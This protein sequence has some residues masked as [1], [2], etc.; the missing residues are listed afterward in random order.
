MKRVRLFRHGQSSANAGHASQDHKSIPLTSKGLEQ[1]ITVA[2]S[3][4]D[5]PHLIVTSPFERAQVTAQST[6]KRFP[7]AALE[8]WP[9]QEF[10]Y[11]EPARCADTTVAQRKEWVDAYW[12]KSH[13]AYCDGVGAESFLDF[14][15]RAQVFLERL[16]AHPASDIAVFSH[17]Q[18]LN[19]VAWLLERMPQ[20]LDGYAMVDWRSYEI[21]NHVQNGGGFVLSR[22]AGD[23]WTLGH[24][25]PP[26]AVAQA[27]PG[28]ELT[29]LLP[30]G[31][32][33][34]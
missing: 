31:F 18:F 32:Q 6:A 10:T 27:G 11:L 17:G 33:H 22:Q 4:T 13:P 25:I 20:V 5:A 7:T 8:T 1:A 30:P 23:T 3:F 28:L 14:V 16:T 29:L 2:K 26:V 24:R 21:E 34:T 9:I 15:A 19:A 12:L